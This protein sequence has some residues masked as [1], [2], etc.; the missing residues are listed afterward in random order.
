MP[1][2]PGQSDEMQH[3]SFSIDSESHL[4]LIGYSFD[5]DVCR[6]LDSNPRT[7]QVKLACMSFVNKAVE[8]L[9]DRHK[10]ASEQQ[11]LQK[12]KSQRMN[13]VTSNIDIN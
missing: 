10:L 1:A 13:M 8:K 5:Y 4:L 9:C 6:G 12:V 2:K 3:L 11:A 7:P